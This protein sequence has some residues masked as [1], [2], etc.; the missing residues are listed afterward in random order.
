MKNKV[1][2]VIAVV[3]LCL[4]LLPLV[5]CNQ[6]ASDLNMEEVVKT[7]KINREKPLNLENAKAVMEE[8]GKII[9]NTQI[10]KSWKLYI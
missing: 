5:G 2:A 10:I 9:K 8:T 1:K 6:K 7:L 4:A 3:G